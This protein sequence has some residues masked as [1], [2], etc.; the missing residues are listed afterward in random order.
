[1]QQRHGLDG[2]MYGNYKVVV[3]CP[4][5][6]RKVA[7]LMRRHVEQH[8]GLVDEF[9][10]WLNTVNQDDLRYFEALAAAD[11]KF[12]RT[13]RLRR[14]FAWN[15]K[16]MSISHFFRHAIDSDALYIR[17]DDDVVWLHED[18]LPNLVAY[19]VEH[20]EPYLIYAN[21]VNSSRFMH[22][23]QRTGAFD[24]GFAVQYEID[25]QTN[26]RSTPAG[27]AAHRALLD[28][29]EFVRD[30]SDG[31]ACGLAWEPW[32]GFRRWIFRSG[33]Y[34]DVN[35]ICW[36]GRDFARWRG[37]CPDEVHEEKWICNI[38]PRREN[39]VNEACGTALCSHYA[40]TPQWPGMEANPWVLD[41]YRNF[42]PPSE[43]LVP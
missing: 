17:L 29:L 33:E 24:P 31:I 1:M 2:T 8:R 6:R 34:N 30:C 26:R 40:S 37:C 15:L 14:K 23:H 38:C 5:G 39:R 25:H 16:H 43:I 22:L 19:R 7:D 41:G 36:F 18:C 9:H 28:T 27:L 35:L 12:Y 20:E 13:I 3:V 21:I 4:A 42:C 32:M 11:S 10:W